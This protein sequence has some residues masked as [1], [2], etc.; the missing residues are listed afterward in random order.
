MAT[1]P[2]SDLPAKLPSGLV[3][4]M[5]AATHAV[6]ALLLLRAFK[7]LDA[8]DGAWPRIGSR[9][10]LLI[11]FLTLLHGLHEEGTQVEIASRSCSL[12]DLVL[13]LFGGALVLIAPW[14][15]GHGRLRS[16]LP[17]LCVL[18]AIGLTATYLA[19][20]ESFDGLL[21]PLLKPIADAI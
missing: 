20:W 13:D 10:G 2:A 1:A 21:A 15:E 17:V 8:A 14:R 3:N 12:A 4:S 5:H 16:F 19:E 11:M 7:P 18:L 6:L 9:T